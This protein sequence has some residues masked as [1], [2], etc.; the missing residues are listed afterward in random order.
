MATGK[1][2]RSRW[3]VFH[4]CTEDGRCTS[5]SL[6]QLDSSW[7]GDLVVTGS[8]ILG[9]TP[10]GDPSANILRN[11]IYVQDRYFISEATNAARFEDMEVLSRLTSQGYTALSSSCRAYPTQSIVLALKSP[12]TMTPPVVSQSS[13]GSQRYTIRDQTNLLSHYVREQPPF[14]N[15]EHKLQRYRNPRWILLVYVLL[16]V[17]S[18][19]MSVPLSTGGC[20]NSCLI[21]R[22]NTD[23]LLRNQGLNLSRV[24]L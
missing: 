21:V 3:L 18:I 19:K 10:I 13:D 1:M 15:W 2:L 6:L 4:S 8:I 22:E 7:E 17:G 16:A 24:H 11:D 9:N 14:Q 20:D 12:A 23:R 5:V